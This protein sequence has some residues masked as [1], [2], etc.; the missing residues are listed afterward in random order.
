MEAWAVFFEVLQRLAPLLLLLLGVGYL[1]WRLFDW[2][3]HRW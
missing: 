1:A 3:C 2:A